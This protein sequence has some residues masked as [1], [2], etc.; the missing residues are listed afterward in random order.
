MATAATEKESFKDL[1]SDD[2]KNRM[3]GVAEELHAAKQKLRVGQF[4]KTADLKRLKKEVARIQTAIR[5]RE[6]AAAG[7]E[8]KATA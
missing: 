6:I 5:A 8:K 4:K 1:T 7:T 2:L 3:N